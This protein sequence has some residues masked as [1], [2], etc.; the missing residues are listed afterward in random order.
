MPR[1]KVLAQKPLTCQASQVLASSVPGARPAVEPAER[2]KGRSP[3]PS[4]IT[5]FDGLPNKIWFPHTTPSSFV[6]VV[7]VGCLAWLGARRP[8][9]EAAKVTLGEP[10]VAAG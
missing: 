3:P 4:L 9:R 2:T 6:L 1:T 7:G 8:L 10:S 5:A